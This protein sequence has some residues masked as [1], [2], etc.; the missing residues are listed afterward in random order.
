MYFKKNQLSK[1]ANNILSST[2]PPQQSISKTNTN[3]QTNKLNITE[4]K[5]HTPYEMKFYI[6]KHQNEQFVNRAKNSN[7]IRLCR[8][9]LY[10]S[11]NGNKCYFNDFYHRFKWQ[12]EQVS[13]AIDLNGRI[14][15]RSQTPLSHTTTWNDFMNKTPDNSDRKD[16]GSTK[17]FNNYICS[18]LNTRRTIYPETDI[19]NIYDK[20]YG[21]KVFRSKSSANIVDLMNKSDY[22]KG[23]RGR[24]QMGKN[25]QENGKIFDFTQRNKSPSYK[26]L[27]GK[28]NIQSY[29]ENKEYAG[30]GKL[31]QGLWGKLGKK[32]ETNK[33]GNY[34]NIARRHKI[35]QMKSNI[36][37][38]E[39][40]Y[41]IRK[42]EGILCNYY[43]PSA[44]Y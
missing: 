32:A 15:N 4:S 24:S 38:F 44:I 19:T 23:D 25:T 40:E 37:N 5:I 31:D 34:A 9:K 6:T 11:H 3:N 18:R 2:T 26:S 33:N 22:D 7:N 17:A 21:K 35:Q 16:I 13:E 39:E 41:T 1:S 42:P 14:L 12:T 30:N 27:R 10:E 20:T 29:K 8:Q 36:F 28:V 43:Q